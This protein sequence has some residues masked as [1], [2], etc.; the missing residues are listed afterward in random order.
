[1]DGFF[2]GGGERRTGASADIGANRRQSAHKPRGYLTK[3][4]RINACIRDYRLCF[5]ARISFASVWASHSVFDP[6]QLAV[7]TLCY[8]L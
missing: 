6:Y 8:G 5:S 4:F 3:S 1:M 7:V 2:F